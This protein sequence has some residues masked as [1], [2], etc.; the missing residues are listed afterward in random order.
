MDIKADPDFSALLELL[1]AHPVEYMSED[2]QSDLA[3]LE[4]LK[5]E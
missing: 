2:G 1:N 3:D 4:M 5:G